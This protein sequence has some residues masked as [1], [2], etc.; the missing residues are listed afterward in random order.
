MSVTSVIEVKSEREIKKMREAGRIAAAILSELAKSVK[1]GLST[2]EIDE[3]AGRQL[4]KYPGVKP[5][6]LGYRGFPA[7]L[8]VSVN[9]EVVHGIPKKNKVIQEGDLVSLDWGVEC[10]GYFG[11][12]AT[13]VIVGAASPQ[14]SRLVAVTREALELAIQAIG[15][16]ARAGDIGHAVQSHVEAN[17][18]GVVR[19][20]VGHGIGRN[21]HEEPPIPNWGEPNKG[22]RLVPGMTIAVEPMVSLGNPEV[23][24]GSDGW[25]AKTKDNS[26]AAHFE[27]TILVT[28]DGCEVLTK[29]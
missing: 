2:L 16:G 19:E 5:A 1:A 14:K 25:T 10:D 12:C 8:C 13:T 3:E 7:R 18:M 17:G 24:I 22:T 26:A 28:S 29:P 23:V 4:E 20:F 21:L 11:D 6:F 27:H 15:P 9:A